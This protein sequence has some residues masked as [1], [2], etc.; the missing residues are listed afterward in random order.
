MKRLMN[1]YQTCRRRQTLPRSEPLPGALTPLP[2]NF[3]AGM[4]YVPMQTDSTLYEDPKA[5]EAGTVFPVLHKP[6]TG[7]CCK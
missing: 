7:K 3:T 4:A 1:E 6:F 5:L 2:A